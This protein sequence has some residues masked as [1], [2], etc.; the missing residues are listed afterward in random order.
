MRGQYSV[1]CARAC[2]RPR[3]SFENGRASTALESGRSTLSVTKVNMAAVNVVSLAALLLCSW[4]F[5]V[6]SSSVFTEPSEW[7]NVRSP[8]V[9]SINDT[10]NVHIVPHTH[11]DVGWL[12]TVDEYYYGGNAWNIECR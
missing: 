9:L 10:I 1:L 5:P 11:D 7:G 3:T 6:A 4:V 8:R 2:A 12:K